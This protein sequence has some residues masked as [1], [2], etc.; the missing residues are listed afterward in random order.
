M[1]KR[2]YQHLE[3]NS[4]H[5]YDWRNNL[6][7][8]ALPAKAFAN[9]LTKNVLLS[10]QAILVKGFETADLIKSYFRL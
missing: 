8:R 6:M 9:D 7:Q 5:R 3:V 1:E 4:S 2:R 10:M